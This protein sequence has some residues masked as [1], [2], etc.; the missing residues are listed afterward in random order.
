M[1][2]PK[3][4]LVIDIAAFGWNLVSHLPEFRP[5]QAV[6][7]ALTCTAQASFRTAATP[8][9]HGIV[10]NGLFF[11]DLTKVLFWEQSATLCAGPRIWDGFRARGGTVGLMFWQQSMGEN[12][13]LVRVKTETKG[14]G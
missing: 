12:E 7:P 9:A 5:A 11:K 10:A 8:G 4:L 1:S 2:I 14:A 3:K 13:D 6:W